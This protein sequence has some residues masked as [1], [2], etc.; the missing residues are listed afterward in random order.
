MPKVP[1]MQIAGET[2]LD[3]APSVCD[4]K[5]PYAKALSAKEGRL[6]EAVLRQGA[7][8]EARLGD[9]ASSRTGD[10]GQG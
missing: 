1:P 2:R 3:E 9:C 7:H 8:C 10:A 4:T 5:D 6:R